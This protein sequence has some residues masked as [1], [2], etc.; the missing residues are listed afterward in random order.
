MRRWIRAF[1]G[2]ACKRLLIGERERFYS[3]NGAWWSRS[4]RMA[5]GGL[6]RRRRIVGGFDMCGSKL[7]LNRILFPGVYECG[8]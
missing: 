6:A 8:R 7:S 4:R 3:L 2:S 5:R 1:R